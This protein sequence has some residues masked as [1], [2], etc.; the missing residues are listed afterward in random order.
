MASRL[1]HPLTSQPQFAT[2][3]RNLTSR[4]GYRVSYVAVP[5]VAV[6]DVADPI[7]TIALARQFR[8]S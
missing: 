8:A 7:E 5:D 3:I 4:H 6:P 2:S 1:R